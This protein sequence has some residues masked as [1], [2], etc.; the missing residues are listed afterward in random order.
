MSKIGIIIKREYLN[1]V[2]KKS[3]LILTFL[4]PILFSA[5]YICTLWLS[6]IKGDEVKNVVILDR[7]GV[8]APL[9]ENTDIINSMRYRVFGKYKSSDD[10]SVF[11]PFKHNRQFIGKS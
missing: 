10:K 9:F 2:S 5:P 7:T 8:Y 4:T 1:R 6:S 3:F 11:C